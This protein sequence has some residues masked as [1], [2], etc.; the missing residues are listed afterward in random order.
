LGAD[1]QKSWVGCTTPGTVFENLI[2]LPLRVSETSGAA[3]GAI[4]AFDIR[5]G[6]L[7]WV[8]NTIPLKG[9]FGDRTWPGRTEERSQSGGANCWAGMSIDRDRGILFVPTGSATPDFWGGAR[10]GENLFANCLLA[11]DVRTGKRLWHFQF[12]HHDLWD[13]DLPAPP[14]LVTVRHAGRRID[15]VAQ[16][17]KDG[18]VFVFDRDTGIPLFPVEE[19]EVPAS[20]LNGENAWPTQPRSLRPAPFVRQELGI[21]DLNPWAENLPALQLELQSSRRGS[22]VPFGLKTTILFP[23]FDGGGEW[24][25]AAVDPDSVLYVNA[26]EMAWLANMSETPDVGSMAT[27]TPGHRAYLSVCVA[28]HGPDRQ[29]NVSSGF[30]ALTDVNQRH[31]REEIGRIILSGKGMMPGFP[32]LSLATRQELVDF[33]LNDEKQEGPATAEQSAGEEPYQFNGYRKFLDVQGYPAIRPPWG[34]LTAIDLNTGLH[35][36]QVN[37][38]EYAELKQRGIPQTGIENYGGPIATA[39]GLLFIAATKDGKFRAFD[40]RNGNMLWESALPACSFATP[41]TYSVK[42][43]QY[44]VVACGGTKLGSPKGDSYVAFALPE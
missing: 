29:G 39:G 13:R 26:S 1:A 15:A 3:P 19:S 18:H 11:L 14:N 22:F 12:V 38:G 17:T 37:L 16:I 21:E 5:N 6:E 30:P 10:H 23:G 25:G 28:C 32:A 34:T 27:F 33:L 43:R 35:R 44:V 8:F 24:G 7:A 9:E 2:I 42:G 4:Q 36:W 40:R 31:S 41:A 20:E